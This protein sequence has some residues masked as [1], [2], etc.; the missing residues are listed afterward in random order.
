MTGVNLRHIPSAVFLPLLYWTGAVMV[1]TFSGYPG[2]ICMTPL[3]WLLALPVGLR[4]QRETESTGRTFLMEAFLAGAL[5]GLFQGLLVGLV[6][7]IAPLGDPGMVSAPPDPFL[8]S[9]AGAIVG[10]PLAGALAAL[11]A[12]LARRSQAQKTKPSQD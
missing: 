5:L 12:W 1:I 10:T 6:M 4:I 8:A 2:V 7:V 3:A 11:I 9:A